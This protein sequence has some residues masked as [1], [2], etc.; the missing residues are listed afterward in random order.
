LIGIIVA[1]LGLAGALVAYPA[2][3]KPG[4][5]HDAQ[6]L[7]KALKECKKDKSKSKRNKCEKTADAKYESKAETRGHK[8]THRGTGT[9][10][11]AA[12]GTGIAT[13]TG[14]GTTGVG[15]ATTGTGTGTTGMGTGPPSRLIPVGVSVIGVK[16]TAVPRKTPTGGT[17]S[18]AVVAGTI[19]EPQAVSEVIALVEGLRRIPARE[20]REKCPEDSGEIELRFQGTATAEPLALASAEVGGCGVIGFQAPGQ[21]LLV[22]LASAGSTDTPRGVVRLV[23][24][25][26]G[27][28]LEAAK[29]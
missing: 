26:L 4:S 16:A 23:E 29:Q 14:I 19:S 28:E 15:A 25:L 11:G 3:A 2:G 21:E 22:L 20:F 18:G 10:T 7:A 27:V 9:G 5:R 24:K 8:G 6:K 12:T 1:T 13:T 17:M